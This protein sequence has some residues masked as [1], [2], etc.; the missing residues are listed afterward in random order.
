MDKAAKETLINWGEAVTILHLEHD[1][2]SLDSFHFSNHYQPIIMSNF[3]NI[4]ALIGEL[5]TFCQG[6]VQYRVLW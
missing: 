6:L 4:I 1:H 3:N 5:E 2:D